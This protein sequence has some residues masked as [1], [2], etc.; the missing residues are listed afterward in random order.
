MHPW[1]TE[2]ARGVVA[3][4]PI[5]KWL[6]DD[7]EFSENGHL[8]TTSGFLTN[9]IGTHRF[10]FHLGST[11]A[12]RKREVAGEVCPSP[13]NKGIWGAYFVFYCLFLGWYSIYLP[14]R[15]GRLS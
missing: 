14:W 12:L 8:E 5:A 11:P 9:K 13:A 2:S 3:C 10:Y 6:T 1:S 4:G 7:L 15:D